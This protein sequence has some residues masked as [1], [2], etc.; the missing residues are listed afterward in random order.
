MK[1]IKKVYWFDGSL[2][3]EVVAIRPE[4]AIIQLFNVGILAGQ[5]EVYYKVKKDRWELYNSRGELCL[6]IKEV[7]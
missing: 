5:E 4:Q 2:A 6:I 3:T 7:G 1:D